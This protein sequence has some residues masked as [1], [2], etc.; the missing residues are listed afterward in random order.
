MCM[1]C[2]NRRMTDF[3]KKEG[4]A[5]YRARFPVKFDQ[6]SD[7]VLRRKCACSYRGKAEICPRCGQETEKVFKVLENPPW[8]N[9]DEVF[10]REAMGGCFRY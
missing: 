2:I 9:S 4:Y 3:V 5:A 7:G 10:F 8:N 1:S 6:Y